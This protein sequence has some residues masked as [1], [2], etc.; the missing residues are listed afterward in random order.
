[1]MTISISVLKARAG[2]ERLGGAAVAATKRERKLKRALSSAACALLGTA[3]A[4]QAGKLPSLITLADIQA[5]LHMHTTWSDGAVSVREMAEAAKQRGRKY[6]VITDHSHSL[7][8]ANG[9]S[10]ERLLEQQKVSVFSL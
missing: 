9:L 1:M 5:D 6:I 4:A 2:D 8:I 3:S 10:I 7:G